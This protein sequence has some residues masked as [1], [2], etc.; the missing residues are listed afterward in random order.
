M[1]AKAILLAPLVALAAGAQDVI[2]FERDFPGAIPARFEVRL[3]AEGQAVYS[4]DGGEPLELAVGPDVA[5]EVF[6]LA[7]E[8]DY[9]NKPLASKRRV[10]STGR[11]L[12]RYESAGALRGEA[13]FDYS[14]DP[15]AREVASWFVKLA[16]T[17]QHRQRLERAYRFDRLGINEAMVLL[18]MSYERDRVVALQIL[19]PILTKIVANDRIMRLARARAEGLLERM[20]GDRGS[21]RK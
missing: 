11:K 15:A 3:S 12:L 6:D 7:A 2:H 20:R 16:E 4:E 18:E 8:L 17:H 13:E 19:E 21:A 5:A 14:D 9:F 10:A 1:L